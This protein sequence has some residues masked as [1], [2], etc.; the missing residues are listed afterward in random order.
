MAENPDIWLKWI[1][2]NKDIVKN[3]SVTYPYFNEIGQL[4]EVY[5]NVA[6]DPDMQLAIFRYMEI[7]MQFYSD[8]HSDGNQ[9]RIF[10]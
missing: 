5:S 4:W 8:T 3:I 7:G 10:L 2:I 9:F 1:N 6:Y